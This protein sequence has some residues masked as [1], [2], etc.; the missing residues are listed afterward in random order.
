VDTHT[1]TH[2][3]PSALVCQP[4]CTAEKSVTHAEKNACNIRFGRMRGRESEEEEEEKETS[5]CTFVL[6]ATERNIVSLQS[7]QHLPTGV[8]RLMIFSSGGGKYDNLPR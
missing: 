5:H 3:H 6:N 8:I 2:T 1:H 4:L 7:G